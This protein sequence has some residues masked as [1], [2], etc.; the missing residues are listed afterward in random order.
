VFHLTFGLP[1]TGALVLSRLLTTAGL[2][3][4]GAVIANPLEDARRAHAERDY[5]R[6]FELLMPLA[7]EGSAVAQFNIGN[8]YR[9]GLGVPQDAGA[10]AKWYRRAALKGYATAQNSLGTMY[11]EGLGVSRNDAEAN[12]W[13]TS[14]E[15][16]GDLSGRANLARAHELGLGVLR[17]PARAAAL[18]LSVL[19]APASGA[20][21]ELRARRYALARLE[22][23]RDT[24][25]ATLIASL[26]PDQQRALQSQPESQAIGAPKSAE[27]DKLRQELA[28]TQARLA[29]EAELRKAAAAEAEEQSRR[30]QEAARLASQAELASREASTTAQ[31]L[32]ALRPSAPV[33]STPT[34]LLDVHALVIGNGAY[35]GSA[36][37]KNPV[38]DARAMAVKLRSFRFRVTQVI[39][40]DRAS[41]VSALSRFSR[42]AS[43]ADVSILFYA[44]HGMQVFGTNYL[45]PIDLD[46]TDIA[47]ATLQ[48]V[49]L[50]AI[51]D[52]YLTGRTKIVFLDACRD[53]PLV[54][55]GTRGTP[56]GLAPMAASEGTL[57]AYAT[58][59]GGVASDGAN[60]RN[61]PFTT[62]LL[63]QLDTNEDIAV[64][65]RRVREQVVKATDGKQQPWEYGSLTGGRFVLSRIEPRSNQP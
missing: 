28:D 65:L 21:A 20:A 24:P 40:A 34:Q 38:N 50:N 19:Q 64:V 17:D 42:S 9:Y 56:L 62:A 37:L 36:R 22:V 59:D 2:F 32:A 30:A 18:Y 47:Q 57:I 43:N 31:Q 44:G 6:S 25:R 7:E 26:T 1:A 39:D 29:Q 63:S 27:I 60:A 5:V 52:Q 53:N 10:A 58:K 45:L 41:L 15:Q 3:V 46:M 61:S 4:A 33:E 51:V 16:A 55:S 23:L 48:G 8:L 35:P 49:S 11:R 54:R 12:R 13:Y 14:A